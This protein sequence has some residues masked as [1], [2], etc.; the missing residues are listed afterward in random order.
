MLVGN[1]NRHVY[2]TCVHWRIEL[3]IGDE[4]VALEAEIASVQVV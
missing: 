3:D 1:E 4:I 2:S